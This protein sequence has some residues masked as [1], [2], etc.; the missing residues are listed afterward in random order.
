MFLY[1]LLIGLRYTRA[2]RRNHFIS[3]IS[4]ISL[5]GI[6][7]GMT[8]L[9]TVMSVMNGFHKE[10]RSRILGV[11][12]HVQIST[13]SGTLTN[14]QQIAD[15]ASKH[16]QVIAAAPYVSAQ[17]M[18]S[19]NQVVRGI[20]V[21][22]ILPDYENRVADFAQMMVMGELDQLKAGEFDI[23]IG[24]ELARSLGAFPGDKIVL[25][26]PQG[27]VTPAGMLPRLK[28][29]TVTSVFEAGHYEY[30][31]GLALIHMADAQKL[32]R[33]EP[34]QVSGVRLKLK[35]MFQ[36]PQ[37]VK[38][39][40]LMVSADNYITDWTHQHAN[41]FRAIQIEKRM[42]SLILALIIAVA[43]FNIVS[44][45]VMAVTDKQPDIA[46]L[47]TLGAS[48]GS[49]MKIFIVQGTLIGVLGTVLGLIGGTLLAYNVGEVVAF[50]ER[51]FS[52]QFLSQEVYYISE[53]PSDPQ[54]DDIVT[55]AVVSF[56]L[57][58]LA[59]LYPSY[60]ASKV[61]PAEAL[62]YE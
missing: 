52:I 28:Q 7:L 17:G 9:I 27:Q 55:V 57:T 35:D 51:L 6:T 26:S 19:H 4:L 42:L 43:A 15:M 5:L 50:I 45:L 20:M 8:A 10:I 58:L 2:K 12:S 33:M 56:T 32:Y 41:Y 49:I 11:A 21:R 1:E 3:F 23:A 46:I 54:L 16:P 37:V 38:E 30:D 48:P 29:F 22:G 53:I 18:L 25:I 24:I 39:L 13:I 62:R 31:S 14:W 34:N 59:T 36:A 44:T 60:R 40:S 47:R 61:N